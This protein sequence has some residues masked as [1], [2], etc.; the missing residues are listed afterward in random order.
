MKLYIMAKSQ[1]TVHKL[2]ILQNILKEVKIFFHFFQSFDKVLVAIQGLG[3]LMW[4]SFS[5]CKGM[6]VL[7][8]GWFL[9]FN[10]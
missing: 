3:G 1:I 10:I 4:Y 8:R 7:E 5:G 2:S 6:F 9:F